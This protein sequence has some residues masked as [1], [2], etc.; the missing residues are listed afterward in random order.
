M[1]RTFQMPLVSI[2]YLES[3]TYISQKISVLNFYYHINILSLIQRIL[4]N[5]IFM[6]CPASEE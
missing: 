5:F 2:V 1:L 6:N 3:K 4:G